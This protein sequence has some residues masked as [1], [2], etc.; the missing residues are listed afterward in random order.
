MRGDGN[1]L[2]FLFVVTGIFILYKGMEWFV[3]WTI[4]K[5]HERRHHVHHHFDD[6]DM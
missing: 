5:I 6:T 1:W 3:K 2:P 4:H